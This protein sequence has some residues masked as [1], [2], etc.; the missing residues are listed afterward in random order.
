M[1]INE[2]KK[3]LQIKRVRNGDKWISICAKKLS[4]RA[5]RV[6]TLL[7]ADCTEKDICKEIL[8]HNNPDTTRRESYEIRAAE[9]EV[10]ILLGEIAHAFGLFVY[11]RGL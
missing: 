2:V 5:H 3:E 1:D 10:N 9:E 11:Q 4:E 7:L 6:L 8:N